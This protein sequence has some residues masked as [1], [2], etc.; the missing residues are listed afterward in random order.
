[1]ATTKVVTGKVRFSFAH[2]FTPQEPIGGGEP[3]YSVTLLIPKSDTKTI[4]VLRAAF[5]AAAD[6][7]R[8]KNGNASLPAQPKTTLKDGDGTRDSGEPFGPE[9]KGCYVLTIS[10][11]QKPVVVDAAKNDIIDPAEVYS[12]CYGRASLNCFAYSNSGNKGLSAGLLAVQKLADGEPF[13]TVGSA[14]DFDDLP[15]GAD[16]DFPF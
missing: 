9:C 10:S 2:L 5:K 15:D 16:D 13:G 4:N 12:G 7:Y 8:A 14:D 1:M 11:K 6:N 3:K